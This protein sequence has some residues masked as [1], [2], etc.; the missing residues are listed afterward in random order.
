MSIAIVSALTCILLRAILNVYDRKIFQKNNTDFLK[1]VVCNTFFPFLVACIVAY[2]LGERNRYFFTLVAQPGVILS[3][4]GAQLAATT[5][6]H[7]FSKMTV[8]SVVVSSKIVDLFIPLIIFIITREFNVT[9]YCFSCL[10]TLIFIPIIIMIAK[11]KSANYYLASLAIV[12]VLLFQA[13]INSYF[14][15]HKFADTWPKFLS[16]MTC[17]LLWRTFFILIPY[18]WTWI[19][20]FHINKE[21]DKKQTDYL[22]L[23]LRALLGFVSQAAFFYSITRLSGNIA[24]PLLNSTPLVSCFT[25]HFFLD[26]AV[27]KTEIAVLCAFLVLS[28]FYIFLTMY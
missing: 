12:C 16:L 4:F 23:I 14:A 8:K 20:N 10:S 6:Y 9:E 28:T 26:E 21:T 1:N 17:I 25:A 13:G 27:G 22:T 5:F 2:T 15:M 3:A 19:Q 18:I 24:W 11:S 7:C